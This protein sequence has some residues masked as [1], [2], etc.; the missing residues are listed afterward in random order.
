MH[1]FRNE[2]ILSDLKNLIIILG[3]FSLILAINKTFKI[4]FYCTGS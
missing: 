2:L 4:L 3:A 1:L